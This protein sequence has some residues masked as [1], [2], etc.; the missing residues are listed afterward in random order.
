MANNSAPSSIQAMTY[1]APGAPGELAIVSSHG[2]ELGV[3]DA[4][5][6]AVVALAIGGAAIESPLVVFH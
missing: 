4:L 2:R 3:L 5:Y 6:V 1:E